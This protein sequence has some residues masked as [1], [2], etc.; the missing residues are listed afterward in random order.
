MQFEDHLIFHV[1]EALDSID[2]IITM[3]RVGEVSSILVQSQMDV[4]VNDI[5]RKIG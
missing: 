2:T 5:W 3:I 4:T 1:L